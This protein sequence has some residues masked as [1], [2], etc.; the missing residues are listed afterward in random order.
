MA[1]PYEL[2][3]PTEDGWIWTELS[4]DK[5]EGTFI[6]T[7]PTGEATV[8]FER[9]GATPPEKGSLAGPSLLLRPS[10]QDPAGRAAAERFAEHLHARDKATGG[11]G[12]WAKPAPPPMEPMR[13]ALAIAWL[14]LFVLALS[15]LIATSTRRERPLGE[16]SSAFRH[17]LWPIGA[18]LA[19]LL[20]AF[21]LR[22]GLATGGPGDVGM[23]F[24]EDRYGIAP[25]V[26][27]DLMKA[28]GLPRHHDS[29]IALN[30]LLGSLAPLLM[31]WVGRALD[32]R[33]A[34]GWLAGAFLA[35]QPLL[36]RFSGEGNRQSVVLFLGLL[37]LGAFLNARKGAQLILLPLSLLA[38]ALCVL[39]RPEALLLPILVVIM[40]IAVEGLGALLRRPPPARIATAIALLAT[41]ALASLATHQAGGR[42]RE[43]LE[44]PGNP[45]NPLNYPWLNPIWTP[46]ALVALTAV[47]CGWGLVRRNRVVFGAILPLLAFS[48]L[49][50]WH[51]A[52]EAGLASTRYYTLGYPLTTFIAAYAL[53]EIAGR[54]GSRWGNV[55]RPTVLFAGATLVL[56]SA[57][58]PLCHVTRPRTLDLEYR[59]LLE[60][61]PTLPPGTTVYALGL[62]DDLG[63]RRLDSLVPALIAPETRWLPWFGDPLPATPGSVYYHTAT[64]YSR[65]LPPMIRARC[66]DSL[67][68]HEGRP[69]STT[70]LPAVPFGTVD[71]DEERLRIGFYALSPD[72]PRSSTTR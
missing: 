8:S 60:N 50:H 70:D 15:A 49:A 22:L 72:Q 69:L 32:P 21:A 46:A 42:L 53:A 19:L 59:W 38:C 13:V 40:A 56:V 41:S 63:L 54:A 24:L 61:A 52:T 12:I 37:G 17:R 47:G 18:A 25:G 34:V 51:T 4:I 39:T 57:L 20:A 65:D 2:N 28:A 33:P 5:I 35:L 7:G 11:T 62:Q 1:R 36:V 16:P 29:I 44:T 64:C 45:L 3:A 67:R 71:Y 10:G 66:V 31:V 27:F 26:L 43:V 30:L 14:G 23:T 9:A 48:L 55:G 6:L 68:H 58:S